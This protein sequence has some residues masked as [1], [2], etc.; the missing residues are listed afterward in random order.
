MYN[1]CISL[2]ML[3]TYL[4]SNASITFLDNI[5]IRNEY[6]Y[7]INR[8]MPRNIYKQIANAES[9]PP[10]SETASTK[11]VSA[12]FYIYIYIYL[13]K[14][15]LIL[16][17]GIRKSFFSFFEKPVKSKNLILNPVRI[18]FK[19]STQLLKFE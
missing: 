8:I 7:Y 14:K 17:S 6:E 5:L 19:R 1:T 10:L 12:S 4:C 9:S 3:Y 18:F 2:N 16:E 11:Q 15:Q 13:I